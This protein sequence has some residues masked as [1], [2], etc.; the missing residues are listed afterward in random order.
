[1]VAS[2][3]N[4]PC[5]LRD[6][7]AYVIREAGAGDAPQLLAHAREILRE[8]QWNVTELQEFRITLEEEESWILDFRRKSHSI[9]LVADVGSLARPQVVGAVSFITQPR[10]RLRHRGRLGIGVQAPYRGQGMGEALLTGATG[11]GRG[12]AGTRARRAIGV[13]PQHARY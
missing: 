2:R 13:R 8:P 3:V 5:T 12:R 7:R 6:G 1:M 9:I 4:V 10:F 11:L